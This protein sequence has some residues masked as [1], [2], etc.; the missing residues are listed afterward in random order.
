[1]NMKRYIL[2]ISL[3]ISAMVGMAQTATDFTANDC[4][5]NSHHLFAELDAGKIIVI[6]F[7]MP[8]GSC[9][10]PTLAADAAV[11]SYA[12]SNPGQVLFY[13]A[14]YTGSGN[15]C[16]TIT[17][18]EST[19][20]ITQDAT[21]YTAAFVRSQYSSVSTMNR[22]VVLGGMNH[23]IYY[24]AGS[25]VTQTT[26]QNAISAALAT[27]GVAENNFTNSD[28]SVSPNP[29]AGDAKV[30]YT[31]SKSMDV[32]IDVINILGENVKTIKL[33]RQTI[34]KQEA[35]IDLEPLNNGVYFI[36][37]NAGKESGIVKFIVNH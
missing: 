10:A 29:V 15:S 20:S 8:C 2:S 19:N 26:V 23:A 16:S 3:L 9:I 37:L 7:V 13:V 36:R 32:S 14:H 12:S 30:N 21:F 33:E 4:V 18:W 34:G 35:Q 31:L 6:S 27:T 1:M 11:Q 22:I 17:G 24:N 28:L 25:G 5:G